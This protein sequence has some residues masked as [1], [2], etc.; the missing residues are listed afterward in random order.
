MPMLAFGVNAI[1]KH[2]VEKTSELAH[3]RGKFCF[4]ILNMAQKFLPQS[5]KRLRT[6]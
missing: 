1:D 2:R 3:L 6:S 4:H 5:Y